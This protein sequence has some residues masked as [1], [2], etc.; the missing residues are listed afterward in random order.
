MTS[1]FLQ[2]IRNEIRLRGYSYQTEK[3]YINWTRQFIYFTNKQHPKDL[4]GK[5][6]KAFLTHLAVERHVAVN[7]Q[8]SALNA[9]VF[10]YDK[11]LEQ[12]LGELGFTLATKQRTLPLVLSQVEI[13]KILM[14]LKGR[15]RLAIELMYGSGLRVSECLGIRVQDIDFDKGS[16]RII[17]AKGRKDRV[18]LLSK[19]LFTPLSELITT[20]IKVQEKDNLNGVGCSMP[21]ALARYFKQGRVMDTPP[22]SD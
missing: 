13:Q 20:A 3:S 18:T 9:L 15:D 21:P 2:S 8:K 22:S 4:G 16:L 12:P 17:N 10:V 14:Q 5:E 7:T 1:P 6:V 11:V 19:R